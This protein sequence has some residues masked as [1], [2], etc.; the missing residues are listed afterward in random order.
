MCSHA[1]PYQHTNEAGNYK[2]SE[3][4]SYYSINIPAVMTQQFLETEE[5]SKN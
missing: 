2:A 1:F 4:S 5:Y 3:T